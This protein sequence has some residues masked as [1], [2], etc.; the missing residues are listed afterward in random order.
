[1]AL[2]IGT[3]DRGAEEWQ[4]VRQRKKVGSDTGV[5]FWNCLKLGEGLGLPSLT[6]TSRGIQA[7][8]EWVCI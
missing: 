8:W 4:Q 1:M 6:L 5:T 3:Y 2:G 7:A